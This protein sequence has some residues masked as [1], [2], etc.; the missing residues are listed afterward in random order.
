MT[1]D[2]GVLV[3][4]YRLADP[5]LRELGELARRPGI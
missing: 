1:I 3:I 2:V 5:R 4:Y